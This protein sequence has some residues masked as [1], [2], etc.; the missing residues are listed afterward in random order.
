MEKFVLNSEIL[1]EFQLEKK[2]ERKIRVLILLPQNSE[3]L[4]KKDVLGRSV[5]GWVENAVSEFEQIKV[6]IDAKQPLA[7]VA[8]KYSKDEDF[9]LVVF[10]DTPLLSKE[11]VRD[12]LDYALTKSLDFCKLPR[13]AVFKTSALKRG[14]FELSGE[15]NFL[16]KDEFFSVFDLASLCHAREIIRQRILETHLKKGVEFFDLNSCSVEC[17]VE[18]EKGVQIFRGNTLCGKTVVQSGCILRE[19][20]MIKD[21]ILGENCEV[22]YSFLS[23]IVLKKGSKVEPF[24]FLTGKNKVN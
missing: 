6:Q 24:T 10:G 13:G 16:G 15:A 18:I 22:S 20:N 11:T 19:N 2:N 3:N 1:M 14:Q 21:S 4:L 5:V 23:S 17:D 8:M 7:E 12:A 9:L